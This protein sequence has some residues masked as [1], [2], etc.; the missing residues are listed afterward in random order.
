M[1]FRFGGN[2]ELR[3][4]LQERTDMYSYSI[5]DRCSTVQD[6]VDKGHHG[7]KLGRNGQKRARKDAVRDVRVY[8]IVWIQYR[9]VRTSRMQDRMDEGI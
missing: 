1:F 3:G 4:C 6:R 8:S 2:I 5:E 7:Y 9:R